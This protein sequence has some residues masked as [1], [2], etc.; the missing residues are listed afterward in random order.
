MLLNIKPCNYEKNSGKSIFFTAALG[1]LHKHSKYVKLTITAKAA[2]L[3]VANES[4]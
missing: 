4:K 1:F 2:I 3:F